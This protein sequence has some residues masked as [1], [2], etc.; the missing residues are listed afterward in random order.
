MMSNPFKSESN[1]I[2]LI[3]NSKSILS[4]FAIELGHF[5][6]GKNFLY[7]TNTQA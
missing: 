2:K 4:V 1:P 5:L 7:E 6:E 3:F